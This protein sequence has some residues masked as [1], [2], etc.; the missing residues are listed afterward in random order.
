MNATLEQIKPETVELL[1]KYAAELKLSV[2]DYL[3]LL[4]TQ[5]ENEL[6]LK[7]ETPDKTKTKF[8]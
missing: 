8:I 5:D 3:R 2:D 1:E 4:L 6:T 7:A